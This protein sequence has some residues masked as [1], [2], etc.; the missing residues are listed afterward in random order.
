MSILILIIILAVL[1]FVHELGHFLIAKKSG[2][3]VDEFA[4]GFPPR[5]W[6]TVKN[7][8]RYAI[9]AIPIGGYV[10]I[11][12]ETADD[13]SLNPDNKNSFLNKPRYIQAAV[14]VG[15]VLFNVLFAWFLLWISFMSGSPQIVSEQNQ[16]Y[17]TESF[18]VITDTQ[19]DSPAQL[20]GLESGDKILS[21]TRIPISDS[22]DEVSTGSIQ[23]ENTFDQEKISMEEIMSTVSSS[24]GLVFIN[25]DRGGELLNFEINTSNEI[26]PDGTPAIGIAMANVGIVKMNF[27][28]AI[29][30]SAKVTYQ[31]TIDIFKGLALLIG[32]AIAG[33]G[34]LDTVAGPVGIVGMVSDASNYGFVYLL[35]FTAFISINLAVL[36]IMPFP[37]LDG[38]RLVIVLIESIIRR[39]INPKF[40]NILNFVGFVILIS[41]MI[42]I[43]WNDIVK[44]I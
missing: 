12:G 42:L 36:N 14:L 26:I 9:N 2:I 37:A 28:T 29:F 25:I 4:I 27:F 18:V 5:I 11:F 34:E 7:G 33:E 20:A 8:T 15:G 16:K 40:V 24:E 32:D 13:E 23:N 41:F 21:V 30:E 44:I 19:E 3:R 39:Q 1:I 31:T 17:V 35:T 10:K 22:N 38:G 6:S 43:T